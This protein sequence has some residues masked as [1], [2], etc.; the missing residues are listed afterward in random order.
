MYEKIK[1]TDFGPTGKRQKKCI[2]NIYLTIIICHTYEI[3][4]NKEKIHSLRHIR[5][6]FSKH[7]HVNIFQKSYVKSSHS[8]IE[9]KPVIKMTKLI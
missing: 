6:R 1:M 4:H 2:K 8:I 5:N 7:W 3:T 9:Y